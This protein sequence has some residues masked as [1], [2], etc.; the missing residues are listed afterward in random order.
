MAKVYAIDVDGTL[1]KSVCWTPE[2]CLDAQPRQEVI[3]A[4]NSL[5][6]VWIIINTA[7][8]DELMPAT[9]RWLRKHNVRY[10]AICNQK[11]PAD[12][13]VDDRFLTI[14]QFIKGGERK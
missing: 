5:Q 11:I 3:D 2:E 13:Y 7:R 9:I 1:T 6:C 10:H 12:Y 4:V 14:E 8:R